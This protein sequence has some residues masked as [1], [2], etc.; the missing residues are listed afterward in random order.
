MELKKDN[1][2][3]LE[4]G[5]C[6]K[7]GGP[8]KDPGLGVYIC[9]KCGH[10]M[11][12]DFGKVKNYIQENGPAN[13]ETLSEKTGVSLKKIDKFLRQGK[14]E[15]PENSDIFIKCES[16]GTDIRYGRYCPAC[17]SRLAKQLSSALVMSE[18]GEVPKKT[19]KM[20]F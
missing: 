7:C 12:S 17:A 20:R 8:L 18:V 13:A 4:V 19:G 6:E 2:K 16:C 5:R 14:I 9:S 11:L 10:Q 3:L 1:L 15:I